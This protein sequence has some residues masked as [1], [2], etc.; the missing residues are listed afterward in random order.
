[1]IDKLTINKIYPEEWED[2][3]SMLSSS[4]I[5]NLGEYHLHGTKK[6][7]VDLNSTEMQVRSLDRIGSLKG[8][9]KN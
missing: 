4:I 1:L 7:Q 9:N 5:G 3:N 8:R 6:I 2:Y